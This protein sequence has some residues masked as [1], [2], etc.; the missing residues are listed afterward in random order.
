M[1]SE[2]LK[3][4][5][6]FELFIWSHLK[7]V[8]FKLQKVPQSKPKEVTTYQPLGTPQEEIFRPPE[9]EIGQV[10]SDTVRIHVFNYSG[11]RPISAIILES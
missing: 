3:P 2:S 10:Y 11:S 9:Y 7:N 8:Q 5:F 6:L 1:F 4:M